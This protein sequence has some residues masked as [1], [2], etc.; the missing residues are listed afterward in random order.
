MSHGF[1]GSVL[2]FRS[3]D[4][5]ALIGGLVSA[6]AATG[7]DKHKNAQFAAWRD[8][9]HVLREQLRDRAFED[10][11]LLLEYELP[12]RSRRP[13]VLLLHAGII[14]VLEFKVGAETHNAAARWQSMSYAMDLRDFHSAS[15]GRIIVPAVCATDAASIEGGPAIE[16]K[17]GVTGVVT[18]GKDDIGQ[19]ILSLASCAPAQPSLSL[20]EW[21]DSIY[22]P[23]PSIIEASVRLYQGNGVRE[24]SHRYAHNLDVTTDMLLR[25]VERTR[26]QGVRTICFVTGVPGA[27]KTLTGLD[28][29]HHSK[30][31]EG[32]KT[33]GVF[34]SGN[35]PLVKV[36]RAALV[37]DQMRKG[38]KKK[39]SEREV[40]TFIQNVHQFLRYYREH[41][42][43]VPR[44]TVV[45]FDEAQRAWNQE[46]MARK[47]ELSISEP[48]ELLD[49]MERLAEWSVVIALVGG[50]QEIYLGEAGLEEWGRALNG[51]N[52]EVVASPEVLS[53]GQSV[54]NHRLF[55]GD[56][57]LSLTV[58]EEPSAHLSVGT[59]SPRAQR[60]AHW[61]NEFLALDLDAARGVM[62]ESI[63]FPCVV[64][65]DLDD[66]R[67]WLRAMQA[68][69]PTYRTG[70]V[71]TSEDQRLRA[72]GIEPSSAFRIAYP[73]EKWFLAPPD[74]VRSS[75]ALEVAA[76]EFECQGLELDWVGL[77]W[78][79]DLTVGPKPWTTWDFRKFRGNR[80]QAVRKERECAY[81][82]NR[83]RVLLTRAR[84]GMVLWIPRGSSEDSTRSPEQFDRVYD[85]LIGAGIPPMPRAG[86]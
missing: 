44:E 73:F 24:L 34:L 57:P 70:L 40:G 31:T 33:A 3:S 59:R 86:S 29:V 77:C 8:Q 81:V 85:A 56:A 43:H 22:A 46:Q 80:W 2:E 63:E 30:I 9:N 23:T 60:W 50:G 1:A 21:L 84:R 17:S 82:L 55:D 78:G 32:T 6:V 19:R 74:D 83:Y 36:V 42:D 75:F 12:R 18:V 25:Q 62:P 64:T 35:G 27:G 26:R 79:G 16:M 76:S 37:A 61:V 14:F 69:E 65:R 71:A 49:V 67:A 45:V 66:A 4:D 47:H 51:R 5:D 72:H 41:P 10:S 54:S 48:A 13:D 7:V 39:E 38:R 20:A 68:T 53:G 52:W 28:V 15:C 11:S 58:H